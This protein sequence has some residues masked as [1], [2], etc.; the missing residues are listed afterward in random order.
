[1]QDFDTATPHPDAESD[2]AGMTTAELLANAA[3]A[4]AAL[5]AIW[6]ALSTIGTGITN[7]IGSQLPG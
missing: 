3:L 2:D 1:M 4:V 6:A 7:W 5:V